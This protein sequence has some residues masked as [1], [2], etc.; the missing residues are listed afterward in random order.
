[1]F[2]P[3]QKRQCIDSGSCRLSEMKPAVLF[4]FCLVVALVVES[5]GE[6]NDYRMR[7]VDDT[8]FSHH[9]VRKSVKLE[10]AAG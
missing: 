10:N 1:M 7:K 4:S 6:E 2:Y 9:S 3:R 8:M 5:F